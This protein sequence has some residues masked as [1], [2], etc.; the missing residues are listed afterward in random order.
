[1]VGWTEPIAERRLF[2]PRGQERGEVLPHFVEQGLASVFHGL[3]LG[4][5]ARHVLREL[6][7]PPST[8]LIGEL[9]GA[10]GSVVRRA[11]APYL[12]GFANVIARVVKQQRKRRNCR[13]PDR[14]LKNGAAPGT[15]E[16]LPREERAAA[17]R[18]GRRV[19]K[20]IP[21]EH[22]L[23]RQAVNVRRADYVVQCAG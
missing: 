3:P 6:V 19:H 15:P 11:G 4:D 16:I 17:R 21:K 5:H 12:V 13:I 9:A 23:T 14:S 8:F 20:R 1:N 22:T 2:G 18:A 7:E 10:K